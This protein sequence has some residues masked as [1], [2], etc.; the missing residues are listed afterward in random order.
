MG[1]GLKRLTARVQIRNLEFH[2]AEGSDE[3]I[4]LNNRGILET[5]AF[6][7]LDQ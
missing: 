2:V 1:D 3:K 6:G 5:V 7:H 4:Y